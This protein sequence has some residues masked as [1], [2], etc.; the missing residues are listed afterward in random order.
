MS[1]DIVRHTPVKHTCITSEVQRKFVSNR[2][3]ELSFRLTTDR[4]TEEH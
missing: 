1:G 3:L 2:A 4:S